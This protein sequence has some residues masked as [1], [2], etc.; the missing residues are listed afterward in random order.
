MF[1]TQFPQYPFM[2]GIRSACAKEL[3]TSP[4]VIVCWA[5]F[6]PPRLQKV[7]DLGGVPGDFFSGIRELL[8]KP[9]G[10]PEKRLERLLDIASHQEVRPCA[11]ASILWSSACLAALLPTSDGIAKTVTAGVCSTWRR[12]WERKLGGV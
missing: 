3:R 6:R 5:S 8:G 1:F 9:G 2:G 7:S 12:E 10:D 4:A 11:S